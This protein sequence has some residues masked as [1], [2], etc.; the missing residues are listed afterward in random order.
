LSGDSAEAADQLETCAKEGQ[1]FVD[2]FDEI[3]LSALQSAQHD[4]ERGALDEENLE[5]V[6]TTIKE[7]IENLSDVE[8]Q[9]WFQKVTQKKIDEAG[10]GL[11]SFTIFEEERAL[12]S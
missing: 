10:R 11:A 9:R 3:V 7:V 6:S 5:R 2:C 1:P 12:V 4:A 8:S